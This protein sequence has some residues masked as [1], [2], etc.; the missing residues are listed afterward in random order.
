MGKYKINEDGHIEWVREFICLKETESREAANFLADGSPVT[1]PVHL[2]IINHWRRALVH[3]KAARIA[4]GRV[5]KS[6]LAL[7]RKQL[8][9]LG[10]KS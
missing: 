2:D 1:D 8:K 9:L 3:R 6:I 7:G 10:D 5:K 4:F